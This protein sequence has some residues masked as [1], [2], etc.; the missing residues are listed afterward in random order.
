MLSLTPW[1]Y[2]LI[3]GAA[4]VSALTVGY[5]GWRT[6]E[7]SI[8]RAEVQATFNDFI[9]NVKAQGE[10]AEKLAKDKEAT[11]KRIKE[12]IDHEYETTIAGLVADNKRLR[13]IRSG[14][15]AVPPAP[16][17]SRNP[18]LACFDRSDLERTLQQL[19]DGVSSLIGEGDTNTAG[20]S[21]AREWVKSISGSK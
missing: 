5:F 4:L 15:R 14:R 1:Y 21:V 2:K 11:D 9:A 12:N 16:P 18:D 7:R 20:L 17:G 13:K 19:D 10:A 3:A 6:H 8:G